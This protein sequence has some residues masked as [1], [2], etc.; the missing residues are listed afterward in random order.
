MRD[1]A[2]SSSDVHNRGCAQARRTASRDRVAT[3]RRRGGQSLGN[4]SANRHDSPS[5]V[6][7]P[8]WHQLVHGH[9]RKLDL[10]ARVLHEPDLR[11]GDA[12][13]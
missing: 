3:G 1:R 5:A 10:L 11:G 4:W 2:V 8:A 6:R 9:L 13:S 7:G 12:L